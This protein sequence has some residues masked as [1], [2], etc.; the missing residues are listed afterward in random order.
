MIIAFGTND[1]E[2]FIEI[3]VVLLNLKYEFT[4]EIWV[5]IHHCMNR[6]SVRLYLEIIL[7]NFFTD[8][9]FDWLTTFALFKPD[10]LTYV[11]VFGKVHQHSNNRFIFLVCCHRWGPKRT[12]TRLPHGFWNATFILLL[13][14]SASSWDQETL[15]VTVKQ[16]YWLP[17]CAPTWTLEM[18]KVKFAYVS[19][20]LEFSP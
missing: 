18:H 15:S 14:S 19:R 3:S 12:E 5:A 6:W 17:Y 13:P 11:K 2:M 4:N 1:N 8:F 20:A 9:D 10:I 16:I 7:I